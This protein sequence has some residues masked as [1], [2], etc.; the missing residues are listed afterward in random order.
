MFA[1]SKWPDDGI[2]ESETTLP[3]LCRSPMRRILVGGAV[4]VII[5]IVALAAFV[6]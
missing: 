4:T 2:A 3:G 5:T 1:P 6:L